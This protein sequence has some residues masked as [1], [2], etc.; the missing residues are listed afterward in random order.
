MKWL[1][2]ALSEITP[3]NNVIITFFFPD[4]EGFL[5]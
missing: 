1:M 4:G 5:E 2:E 3:E